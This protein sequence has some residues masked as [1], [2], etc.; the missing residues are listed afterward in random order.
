MHQKRI[1]TAILAKVSSATQVFT[2]LL[3]DQPYTEHGLD[4]QIVRGCA[5]VVLPEGIGGG[6]RE[7]IYFQPQGGTSGVSIG[8]INIIN[9]GRFDAWLGY[10]F[11]GMEW[12]VKRLYEDEAWG[13]REP[14]FAG[15]G[16]GK[17][18]I[19]PGQIIVTIQH[20]FGKL[21]EPIAQ[22][23][24][25]ASTANESLI[26]T[27]APMVFGEAYQVQPAL[28]E[29]NILAHFSASNLAQTYSVAEGGNTETPQYVT[30]PEG[31]QLLAQ[32]TRV[33]TTDI[34]GPPA[35]LPDENADVLDGAGQFSDWDSS[36]DLQYPGL[37]VS[38]TDDATLTEGANSDTGVLSIDAPLSL[39]TGWV[40]G[41]VVSQVDPRGE[42]YPSDWSGA[43][44][45]ALA[46]EG[47][48]FAE[49]STQSYTALIVAKGFGLSVPAGASITGIEIL[50]RLK[51]T[52]SAN[53]GV[54]ISTLGVR[55]AGGVFFGLS[56][57]E[58]FGSTP[59]F[60][61]FTFGGESDDFGAN[62]YLTAE[63]VNDPQFSVMFGVRQIDVGSSTNYLD[64]LNVKIHYT[65]AERYV[66]FLWAGVMDVG[67]RYTVTISAVGESGSLSADWS[68][69]VDDE[70]PQSGRVARVDGAA[71]VSYVFTA[72]QPYFDLYF[73]RGDNGDQEISSITL[74]KGST[75]INRYHNLMRYIISTAGYDPDAVCDNESLALVQAQADNPR[76]GHYITDQTTREQLAIYLSHSLAATCWGGLDGKYRAAQLRIPQQPAGP[77]LKFNRLIGGARAVPDGGED[78]RDRAHAARNFYPIPES[79][80]AGVTSNW[81]RNQR[82]QILADWRITERAD[83]EN[84]ID[85]DYDGAAF[86]V[87]SIDPA[88]GSGAGGTAV[89]IYGRGFASGAAVTIG[90]TAATSVVVVDSATITAVT[91]AGTA[92]AVDVVVTVD[93]DSATLVN[94]FEYSVEYRALILSD[95][96][97]NYWTLDDSVGSPT[98]SDSVPSGA[99]GTVE[100]GVTLGEPPAI[101]TGFSAS[102]T[103][104]GYIDCG[105]ITGGAGFTE[106]SVEAWIKTTQSGSYFISKDGSGQ[107]TGDASF[108]V[109]SGKLAWS[110]VVGTAIVT[111]SSDVDDGEWH[112]VVMSYDGSNYRLYVDGALDGSAAVSSDTIWDG[113]QPF[114]IGGVLGTSSFSFS[115]GI[116]EVAVYDYGLSPTQVLEHYNV[117]TS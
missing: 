20:K 74:S 82:E 26:N 38:T 84:L 4:S 114:F 18:S 33:I 53:E 13:A 75:S 72:G 58:Y 29:P 87:D 93:G 43:T 104:A 27:T 57:Q 48:D 88:T 92:G 111:G 11:A 62:G 98:V 68:S 67:E 80:A 56:A 63:M 10:N 102:F 39:D 5:Q 69:S 108:R 90:G 106:L 59:A 34:A 100:A 19:E 28:V 30:L 115:G 44:A 103:A 24:F 49:V 17:P 109:I 16:A 66:R 36:G 81:T 94:G 76:L 79:E 60:T 52:E 91:P 105:D 7:R 86:S 51:T 46:N 96:P 112:H 3:T 45:T 95:S 83:F 71:Q 47:G 37:V 55:L 99:D 101:S 2:Y 50:A 6:I 78:L 22:A 14:I 113:T 25:D 116:D 41:A 117:G 40:S 42:R 61:D 9:D 1:I 54:A 97:V 73:R 107:N 15:V 32:N 12:T 89:A 70:D 85:Y 21:S 64:Q 110:G 31:F 23:V 8:S 65:T 35:E 77:Y